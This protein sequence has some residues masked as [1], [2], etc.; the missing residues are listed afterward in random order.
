MVA[1][2]AATEAEA[3]AEA[4]DEEAVAKE[5]DASPPLTLIKRASSKR[6]SAK[7]RAAMETAKKE[8]EQA[9]MIASIDHSYLSFLNKRLRS[10]KKKLEKIKSLETAR[11]EEGKVWKCP[12]N[13]SGWKRMQWA[14]IG[15]CDA[16]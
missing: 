13:C 5:T 8:E 15:G 11:S 3:I 7:A 14:L 1:V 4:T 6:L 10:S 16:R 12:I 9:M 2:E